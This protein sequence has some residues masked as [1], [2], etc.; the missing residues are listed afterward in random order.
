[1]STEILSI[2]E[3]QIDI[4][5]AGHDAPLLQKEAIFV[6]NNF[7]INLCDVY[8][9]VLNFIKPVNVALKSDPAFLFKPEYVSSLKKMLNYSERV[10]HRDLGLL[11]AKLSFD[12]WFYEITR[13]GILVSNYN[14]SELVNITDAAGFLGVTRPTLYKY[15]ERGLETVGEKNNQRIPRFILE[16]WR[17]PKVAFQ[18]QW[19]YQLKRARDESPQQRLD[20]INRSIQEFELEYGNSFERLFGK[21][22]E[23][24]IDAHHEAVD[25]YDW[26]NLEKEKQALLVRLRR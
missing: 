19:I 17:D 3:K 8:S 22:N 18:L 25:I 16:A 12:S 15:I 20:R 2:A 11:E 1:M 13:T 7:A 14:D 4:A 10:M 23:Q 5:F 24:E 21:L 9:N 6:L 26:R